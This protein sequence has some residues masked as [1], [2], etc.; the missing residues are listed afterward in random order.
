MTSKK[1][2]LIKSDA[3][4][5]QLA[6]A[7]NFIFP[8]DTDEERVKHSKSDNIELVINDK[9]DEVIEELFHHFF[10]E[11]KLGSKYQSKVGILSLVAFI[12]CIIKCDHKINL[13]WAGSYII[14]PNWIKNKKSNNKSHQ[15]KW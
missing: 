9:T 1:F 14:S 8:K 4:K 11:L 6:I 3:W 5:I 12:Y 7:I 15:Y 13:N 2:A 10:L